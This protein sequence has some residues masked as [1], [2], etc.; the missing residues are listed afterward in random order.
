MSQEEFQTFV[1]NYENDGY[2]YMTT[3]EAVAFIQTPDPEYAGKKVL[4]CSIKPSNGDWTVDESERFSHMYDLVEGYYLASPAQS[5]PNGEYVY[6][7]DATEKIKSELFNGRAVA[8]GYRA[9]QAMPGQTMG[10]KPFMNFVDKNGQQTNETEEAT[11]WAQYSY[12]RTYDPDDPDS[13]NHKIFDP[14]H[15]VCIVGYDDNFPKE[16]FNDPNGTLPANGAFLCKNSWG[17]IYGEGNDYNYWGNDGD[18]YFWLSYYDQSIESPESY[19]FADVKESNTVKTNLDMYDLMPIIERDRV[20]FDNDV[21]M[22]NVFTVKNN[23]TIR[24]IGLETVEGDTTV[25]YSVYLLNKDWKSPVDGYLAVETQQT[26]PNAGYHKIDLGRSFP[27][28]EGNQYSVVVKAVTKGSSSLFFNHAETKEGFNQFLPSR[29]ARAQDMGKT[30]NAVMPEPICSNGVVNKGESYL[31]VGNGSNTEWADWADVTVKLKEMN[32]EEG[33]D[34]F[35]YDNFSIR[36][37]P[38]TENFTATNIVRDEKDFYSEGDVLKGLIAV[39]NNTDEDFDDDMEI[40]LVLSLCELG[41]DNA[42]AKF[43][44]LKA[45]EIRTVEYEYVVTEADVKAGKIDSTV[46]VRVNGEEQAYEAVFGDILTFTVKTAAKTEESSQTSE[47]VSSEPSDTPESSVSKEEDIKV[48]SDN[49]PKTGAQDYTYLFI[50]AGL[51][52]VVAVCSKK[53][54]TNS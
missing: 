51:S 45:G 28:A 2:I 36:S 50:V 39:G 16:Y 3:N 52:I 27:M 12:D 49:P 54:K 44:G 46:T 47:T 31:G 13:I 6:C 5:G 4:M 10:D 22:A 1:Q 34:Y 26:F 8:I 32:V 15:I 23:C 48:P 21:Y 35:T 19:R 17:S 29:I 53:R 33:T 25:S 7:S 42:N 9:D 18:G 20:L 37:Y 41:P 14:V 38:E 43:R 40:E 30:G 24:Y 11:T